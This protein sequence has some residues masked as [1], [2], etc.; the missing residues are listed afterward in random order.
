MG[1][2]KIIQVEE[3]VPL[4]LLDTSEY[5]AYVCHVRCIRAGAVRVRHQSGN[6][7]VYEWCGYID[8]YYW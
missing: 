8:L 1:E 7:A 3:K 6:C 5:P 4:N 2:R